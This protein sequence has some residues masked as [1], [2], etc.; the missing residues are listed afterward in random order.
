M[1]AETAVGPNSPKKKYQWTKGKESLEESIHNVKPLDISLAHQ[2]ADGNNDPSESSFDEV[3]EV[4]DYTNQSDDDD[5]SFEEVESVVEE[6]VVLDDDKMADSETRFQ[7]HTPAAHSVG[8]SDNDNKDL[9]WEKP[10][11]TKTAVLRNTDKGKVL[12]EGAALSAPI[13]KIADVAAES[14]DLSFKKPDWTTNI[15]LKSTGKGDVLKSAGDLAR[16]ITS[17]PH[18][19][20]EFNKSEPTMIEKNNLV[21]ASE[22]ESAKKSANDSGEKKIEWE[23]PDWTKKPVLKGSSKGEQLKS[24]ATLSR[25]IGGIKPIDD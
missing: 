22:L 23:K 16:P 25:P 20:K 6:V 13:T 5:E 19:G 8:S 1:S 7:T 12:K 2:L 4:E 11:W 10:D 17:L 14:K 3:V 21:P 24:G 15:K 9:S 18:I